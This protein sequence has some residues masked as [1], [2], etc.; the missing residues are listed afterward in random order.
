LE[1]ETYERALHLWRPWGQSILKSREELGYDLKWPVEQAVAW[2]NANYVKLVRPKGVA[3]LARLKLPPNLLEYW[4]DC[5]YCDYQRPDGS[6]DF[7]KIRRCIA[8][9]ET[10]RRGNRT[11][12][13]KPGNK[14]LPQ[15]P[16]RGSIVHYD[17][18]DIY[19]PWVRI[20]IRLYTPLASRELLL[21]AADQGWRTLNSDLKFLHRYEP[22]PLAEYIPKAKAKTSER[23]RQALERYN[24]GEVDFEGL[25]LEEWHTAE[26]Q[27][28]LR[29]IIARFQNN[30]VQLRSKHWALQKRVY[31]RV[32][33]WFPE[34]KPKVKARGVWRERLRLPEGE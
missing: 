19:D 11:G 9:E 23:K 21:A 13:W 14:S 3:E 10:D 8:Y 27:E 34:P 17:E 24:S 7:D 15:L 16:Y 31:D 2:I 6:S 32:R 20:E 29:I 5:L 33:K 26:I 18:E 1:P 25:M 30:P 28:D 22:H 12:R 4:E